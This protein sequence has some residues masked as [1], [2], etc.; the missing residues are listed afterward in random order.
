MGARPAHRIPRGAWACLLLV[1][2]V[3]A[4]IGQAAQPLGRARFTDPLNPPAYRRLDAAEGARVELG[5]EVFNTQWVVAGTPGAGR[6][7]GLGPLQLGVVR[8]L[9]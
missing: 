2:G 5:L 9:P 3:A 8:F 1:G 7:D 4:T 6:R